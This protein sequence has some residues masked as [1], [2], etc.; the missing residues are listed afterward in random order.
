[1]SPVLADAPV[2]YRR[3]PRTAAR[4]GELGDRTLETARPITNAGVLFEHPGSRDYDPREQI[5][6]H[7]D[8]PERIDAI[9]IALAAVNW[10][11][12]QRRVA[13]ATTRAELEAVHDPALIDRIETL[14][15]TGGG[16][17]DA[18]V[19]ARAFR[20]RPRAP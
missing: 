10:L 13:P 9:D 12:W 4:V 15:A 16:L 11:G 1:M 7:P 18:A 8:T 17:I 14:V 19:R 6:E 3:R 2:D 20:R 5:A